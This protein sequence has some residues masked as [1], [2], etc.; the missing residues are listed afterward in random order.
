MVF[1]QILAGAAPGD[2]VTNIAMAIDEMVRPLGPSALWG[3]HV[4]PR[5]AGQVRR[6]ADL[7]SCA[8]DDDIVVYHLSIGD[9]PLADLVLRR[10]GRL[11][12]HHHNVTPAHFFRGIDPAFA[13]LLSSG[14]SEMRA[15]VARAELVLADSEFNAEEVRPHTTAPVRVTPPPIDLLA[16]RDVE[17][18][19]P[20]LHHLREAVGGPN[21]LHIGQLMPHKRPDM[22]VAAMYVL[23]HEMGHDMSMVL[24]GPQRTPAYATQV[25][26]FVQ[27]LGLDNVWIAGE[28][29][30]PELVAHYQGADIFVTASE[31]EGFCVP[32]VEAFS[33][34]VPVV[35]RR[36][37]AVPETVGSGG[38][39]LP[40]DS[41]A[42]ELAEALAAVASDAPLRSRLSE[43]AR[44]ELERFRVERTR[45]T[46]L[47]ALLEVIDP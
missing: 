9:P 30:L 3:H 20:T 25:R 45:A 38:L 47:D 19:A 36:F 34:D 42:L 12:V 14:R 4:D 37:G 35:A 10:P 1:H 8:R 7:P 18:H 31:H 46:M 5:V 13:R 17:P 22:L 16:L 11:I 40:S 29:S 32:V 28:V 27:E 39:V 21:L 23:T 41:R 43:G 33:F 26:R 2:A 6:I 44:H 15:L 24:A